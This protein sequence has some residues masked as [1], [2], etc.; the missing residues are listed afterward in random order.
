MPNFPDTRGTA[1]KAGAKYK[2]ST[3]RVPL[4][5]GQD[6]RTALSAADSDNDLDSILTEM[7][8]DNIDAFDTLPNASR[9]PLGKQVYV[10]DGQYYRVTEFSTTDGE[11]V[12]HVGE[13][14]TG[15]SHGAPGIVAPNYGAAVHNPTGRFW[16]IMSVDEGSKRRIDLGLDGTLLNTILGRD[17]RSGDQV[18]ITI[19]SVSD[20]SIT[21]DVVFTWNENYRFTNDAGST[22]GKVDVYVSPGVTETVLDKLPSDGKFTV[23][24]YSGATTGTALFTDTSGEKVWTP[25]NGEK[26]ADMARRTAALEDRA[27]LFRLDELPDPSLYHR[28]RVILVN[29][30]WYRLARTSVTEANLFEGT[31]GN[32][33]E[34][35]GTALWRG[36]SGAYGQNGV[37]HTGEFTANPDHAVAMV[38]ASE[39]DRIRMSIKQSAFEEAKGSQFATTDKVAFELTLASGAT[40]TGVLNYYSAYERDTG[41]HILWQTRGDSQFSLYSA[42][43]NEAW[44]LKFFT[45]DGDGNA[46]TTPFMTHESDLGHWVE[47]NPIADTT[48]D[49]TGTDTGGN[50]D[51]GL[52]A[53]TSI[54][55]LMDGPSLAL[56]INKQYLWLG[57]REQSSAAPLDEIPLFLT[58]DDKFGDLTFQWA[59]K[60]F[61]ASGYGSNRGGIS[62]TRIQ[63]S[64]DS[65][66]KEY[67]LFAARDVDSDEKL[68]CGLVHITVHDDRTISSTE[69]WHGSIGSRTHTLLD[70]PDAA[71]DD[72]IRDI[73]VWQQDDDDYSH[74]QLRVWALNETQNRIHSCV[75]LSD[76]GTDNIVDA[77][78]EHPYLDLPETT[79]HYGGIAIQAFGRDTILHVW[80]SSLQKTLAYDVTGGQFYRYPFY[81]VDMRFVEIPEGARPGGLVFNGDGDRIYAN[82]WDRFTTNTNQVKRGAASMIYERYLTDE[83]FGRIH[84][85]NEIGS[86]HN[87][88]GVERTVDVVGKPEIDKIV[89]LR[90]IARLERDG[91]NPRPSTHSGTP[92]DA[93][94]PI[95]PAIFRKQIREHSLFLPWN[96]NSAQRD[97]DVANAIA[98]HR[99]IRFGAGPNTNSAPRVQMGSGGTDSSNWS[100]R[101]D[102]V[103]WVDDDSRLIRIGLA[104]IHTNNTNWHFN[105]IYLE[106]LEVVVQDYEVTGIGKGTK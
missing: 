44:T 76:N 82:I 43:S 79:G 72:V 47:W 35:L 50:T 74:D 29:D 83:E 90:I 92:S 65:A 16:F 28:S 53:G 87:G 6:I 95:F 96:A 8:Q 1:Q 80:D 88:G 19:T 30:V 17:A 11:F 89:E 42:A 66:P 86:A 12:A 61:S 4:T 15:Y 40:D 52:S 60:L 18:T 2:G 85:H 62:A 73:A 56:T 46:T 26:Y 63:F 48:H 3:D 34:R 31:V 33:H 78:S 98:A 103:F 24:V 101:G 22:T 68:A 64:G 104:N 23:N 41:D 97:T 14:Q 75:G 59:T 7:F 91:T 99:S 20:S 105:W 58:P 5:Y 71:E 81:D 106:D 69:T 36:T 84:T 54:D 57:R 100:I 32:E 25:I 93:L 102:L 9:Y 51:P 10:D 49:S 13:Y 70:L 77:D 38:I 39:A 21:E 27:S 94:N 55:A 45:V 67:L 37:P